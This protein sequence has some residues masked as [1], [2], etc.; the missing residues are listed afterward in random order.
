LV[1]STLGTLA[2]LLGL[3]NPLI[4]VGPG[5]PI[6]TATVEP[7]KED[8]EPVQWITT[9]DPANGLPLRN[10]IKVWG[11]GATGRNEISKIP[12][13]TPLGFCLPPFWGVKRVVIPVSTE[14]GFRL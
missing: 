12:L 8:V 2:A 10:A 11:P 1:L 7:A 4:P 6:E 14:L 9:G 5:F 13:S 3:A